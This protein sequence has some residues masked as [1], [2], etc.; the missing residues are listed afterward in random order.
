MTKKTPVSG[1]T[2]PPRKLSDYAVLDL[3]DVAARCEERRESGFIVTPDSVHLFAEGLR[4]LAR[5][6]ERI[7]QEGR[8]DG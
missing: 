5:E 7:A 2:P 8:R 4:A 3:E 1:T 6:R